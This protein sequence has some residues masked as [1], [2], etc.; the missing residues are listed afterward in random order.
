MIP[1]PMHTKNGE[2]EQGEGEGKGVKPY[3][4]ELHYIEGG[5]MYG[6]GVLMTYTSYVSTRQSIIG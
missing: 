1:F 6:G 4:T 2:E 5:S 3:S